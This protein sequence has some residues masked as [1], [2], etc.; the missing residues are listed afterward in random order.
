MAKLLI[1]FMK[2][3]YFKWINKNEA[4]QYNK[5]SNSLCNDRNKPNIKIRSPDFFFCNNIEENERT[6][7]FLWKYIFSSHEIIDA[8]FKEDFKCLYLRIQ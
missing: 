4:I 8:K 3:C 2:K 7:K 6:Y 5:N 1:K